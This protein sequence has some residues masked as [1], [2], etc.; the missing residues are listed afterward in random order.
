MDT[1][2]VDRLLAQL[3]E[4]LEAAKLSLKREL[5]IRKGS[6]RREIDPLSRTRRTPVSGQSVRQRSEN[7]SSH[8]QETGNRSFKSPD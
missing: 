8:L 3:K 4:N 2:A 1:T 6:S 5:M 7:R